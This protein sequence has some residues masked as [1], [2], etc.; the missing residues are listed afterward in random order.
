MTGHKLMV[1]YFGADHNRYHCV[2]GSDGAFWTGTGWS[3][4]LDCAKVYRVHRDAQRDCT[5]LQ[6]KAYRGLPW[7]TFKVEMRIALV[8][9]NVAAISKEDLERYISDAVRIDVEN[10][11]FGDGPVEGSFVQAHIILPTLEET[12]PTRKCF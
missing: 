3:R 6:T 4:I 8:A 11:V 12:E 5:A 7:R 10:S 9:A 1:R 2:Q